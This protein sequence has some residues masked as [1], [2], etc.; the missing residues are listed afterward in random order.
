MLSKE[1][2]AF[3]DLRAQ[4]P[5]PKPGAPMP[6]IEIRRKGFDA[7][8]PAA[9]E[10][11]RIAS[12]SAAGVPCEWVTAPGVDHATRLLYLHG[13]GYSVGSVRSHRRIA[14]D[15]SRA[16][17][18]A[19]L[20]VDYRLAP[21]NTCPAQ[22]DDALSAYGWMKAN[23]PA[24]TAPATTTFVAGDSAGGGLTLALLVA[25]RD[26]GLPQ[27]AAAATFSAWTDM[28]VTGSSVVT[29]VARD[30]I[31]GGGVGLKPATAGFLGSTD[32]R[33]VQASPVFADYKGI[34]PLYMNV[35]DEEV[36]LDDTLRVASRASEAGVRVSL[37]VEPGAFHVYPFFVP[38]AP[39][40]KR[41]IATAAAFL[42]RHAEGG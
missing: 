36:L 26:R 19:V 13:G 22:L 17:G 18:C 27:P 5:R 32:S 9:P 20:N 3:L 34:A 29:R 40:S 24:D 21:E 11:T 30:P 38:E 6:D 2:Q 28:T 39:E 37:H 15:L 23:S 14:A 12:V 10:D 31:I 8:A 41:A 1:L 33:S 16:A 42:R 4:M 7:T 25:L 35:G